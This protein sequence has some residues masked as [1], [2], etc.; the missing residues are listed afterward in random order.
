VDDKAL[1]SVTVPDKLPVLMIDLLLDEFN[2]AKNRLN[3][4]LWNRVSSYILI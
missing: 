4:G 2:G 3:I 1:I